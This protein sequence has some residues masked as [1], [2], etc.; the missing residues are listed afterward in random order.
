METLGRQIP[1]AEYIGDEES[2]KEFLTHVDK[3]PEFGFD[4]ETTGK[5]NWKDSV[6]FFSLA[7]GG[8]RACLPSVLLPVFKPLLTNPNKLAAIHNA[9]FDMHSVANSGMG[10][11]LTC[12]IAC[13]L[14]MSVREDSSRPNHDLKS[15]VA[16]GLFPRT[17][18]RYMEYPSFQEL[19]GKKDFLWN[20]MNP[21]NRSVTSDY[22]STDA[23]NHLI[24]FRELRKRLSSVPA[25]KNGSLWDLFKSLEMPM[26][27]IL[28]D[29]E[30]A[31]FQVDVPRLKGARTPISKDI[32]TLVAQ[33]CQEIGQPINPMSTPQLSK[34]LYEMWGYKPR[35]FTKGG[36]TGTRK[37]SVDEG[38]LAYLISLH[39]KHEK[40]LRLVLAVREL[41][42]VRG[43]YIDGFIKLL[44]PWDRIHT[45]FKQW[46]TET[47]R[48]SSA[49]PNMQNIPAGKNDK[50]G[51][52]K[53]FVTSDDEEVVDFDLDQVEMRVLAAVSGDKNMI[54]LINSGQDIHSGTVSLM[55][56]VPYD[57]IDGAKKADD[58]K[59]KL[60]DRQR[61]LLAFRKAC[62][63]IG[64]GIAF[65]ASI[66]K[67]AEQL[68]CSYDEAAT[69]QGQWFGQFPEI[70]SHVEK[71]HK[72]VQATGYVR[73][74]LGWRRYFPAG[75]LGPGETE[76]DHKYDPE[77]HH[78][79]RAAGNMI[80]QGS[81][82]DAIKIIMIRIHKDKA[83]R[84]MGYRP[85]LTVHD[86]VVGTCPK[87]YSKEAAARCRELAK[88][89]FDD[90][91]IGLPVPI[92]AG[93]SRGAS[94]GEAK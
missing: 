50:Y 44:D 72:F 33:I 12:Q 11:E 66:W 76:E 60:T 92:T 64:F 57:E 94:W 26:T 41:V 39:D 45:T 20:L 15:L 91:D 10:V 29:Y 27:R 68:G 48:L 24:I 4:T 2:A 59:V 38:E 37:P 31:G 1:K 42:K 35:K 17:D 63:S 36:R 34:L 53:C 77:F 82:A 6:V 40:I 79:M 78:A 16:G 19:F 90:Y 84:D 8:R 58:E 3:F 14:T 9:K 67:L 88:N 71:A 25:T 32:E 21:E 56:E 43:T 54:K 87:K 83:L 93:A 49:T 7:A 18:P 80:I 75:K 61:E 65:E 30:R 70:K 5:V 62:K 52:R 22:A 28:W 69:K 81:A 13:T 86:E 89:P 74:M 85:R 46:G 73:S 23:W 51:L 47:T 55:Y